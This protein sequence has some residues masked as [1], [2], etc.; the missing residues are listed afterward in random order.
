MKVGQL[1][2]KLIGLAMAVLLFLRLGSPRP[3]TPG[4][5]EQL[6]G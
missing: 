1:G 2:T 4:P 6:H 3:A 5:L